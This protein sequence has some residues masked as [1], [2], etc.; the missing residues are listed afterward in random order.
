MLH[1]VDNIVQF[2]SAFAQTAKDKGGVIFSVSF[3]NPENYNLENLRN[4][5]KG[6]HDREFSPEL[7]KAWTLAYL[8]APKLLECQEAVNKVGEEAGA[9]NASV[10]LDGLNYVNIM[11]EKTS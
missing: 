1:R 5:L 2:L 6:I 10:T 8:N 11:I 4:F 7:H 3:L 9:K